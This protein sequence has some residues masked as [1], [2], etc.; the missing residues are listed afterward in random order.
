MGKESEVDTGP[1]RQEQLNR[2]RLEEA[3]V[4]LSI[5]FVIESSLGAMNNLCNLVC[6]FDIKE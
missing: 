2:G 1:G 6:C 4:M 5:G 3:C